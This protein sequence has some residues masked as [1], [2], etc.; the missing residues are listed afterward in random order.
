MSAAPVAALMEPG[1]LQARLDAILPEPIKAETRVALS[2]GGRF[3]FAQSG[4]GQ[5]QDVAASRFPTGCITKLLIATLVAIAIDRRMFQREHRAVDYLAPQASVT[6]RLGCI[7][8]GQ[9]LNHSHGLD[10]SAV[11][12]PLRD[13]AGLLDVAALCEAIGPRVLHAPGEYYSYASVGVWILGAVL[14][15]AFRA[16]LIDILQKQLFAQL[17][18]GAGVEGQ[19]G[20]AANAVDFCPASG[21]GLTL[22]LRELMTFMQAHLDRAEPCWI[23]S[24]QT[25]VNAA[26]V[27]STPGFSPVERG[28]CSGWKVYGSGWLGHNSITPN[29]PAIVR[30]HPEQRV[31]YAVLCS[32]RAPASIAVALFGK[33]LPDSVKYT[34]PKLLSSEARSRFD[35]SRCVGTYANAA[36]SIVISATEKSGLHASMSRHA[37]PGVPSRQLRPAEDGV[38]LALPPDPRLPF[39]Q[40]IGSTPVG[41]SHMW[42]GISLRPRVPPE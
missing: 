28:V 29:A 23:G 7:T 6:G 40:G 19:S 30:V 1:A 27:L 2:F 37:S 17:D 24:A 39:L 15:R 20:A 18:I 31:A 36:S 41:Y 35:T 13:A 5:P 38:L 22:E 32:R 12:G 26:A 33:T 11:S 8:I 9:L 4:G 10:D 16:P 14:E 21:G 42:D 3:A 34:I 25:Q